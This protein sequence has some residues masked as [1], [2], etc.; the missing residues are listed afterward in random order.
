MIRAKTR[1][2]FLRISKI[3]YTFENILVRRKTLLY[4]YVN[5]LEITSKKECSETLNFKGKSHSGSLCNNIK[6]YSE[7]LPKSFVTNRITLFPN[8]SRSKIHHF[9]YFPI[10]SS[11]NQW[12]SPHVPVRLSLVIP[13]SVSKCLS[14]FTP[15]TSVSQDMIVFCNNIPKPESNKVTL[16]F[17]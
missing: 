7:E 16:E 10:I 17:E 6:I 15:T 4:F 14:I 12:T 13:V 8:H 5:K 9:D 11:S 1:S 2:I 3:I